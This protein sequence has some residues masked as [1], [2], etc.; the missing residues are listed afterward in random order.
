M[1]YGKNIHS[2]ANAELQQRRNQAFAQAEQ[3][4]EIFFSQYPRAKEI[5]YLLQSTSAAAGKAVLQ[6][7]NVREALEALK[8]E[9]LALQNELTQLYK[10]AGITEADLQEQFTCKLCGDTGNI[11]GKQCSCVRHLLKETAYNEL[12]ALSP[13]ALSTFNSFSLEYYP[14]QSSSGVNPQ[15]RMEQILQ[16]C[17]KYASE[18][19]SSSKSL[20]MRGTTGL[21]KTHLSLAIANEV[22]ENGFGVIYC[23][24]P[25]ILSKLEK[26][27]F[28][29]DK[30]ANENT[31]EYLTHCDLLILDDLG[32][33][34]ITQFTTSCIYNI[35]NTRIMLGLPT[36]I[37]TNM[38]FHELEKTYSQR[39]VSRIMGNSIKLDFI[40]ND[41]R[42]IKA[43]QK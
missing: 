2:K 9:N 8:N 3:K 7:Q 12:N 36:I 43:M 22:I 14:T 10:Q 4:K 33:E 6:G 18:F 20:L 42:Q 35:L 28:S 23:S 21:G 39:F 13:L 5:E 38:D 17:K 26:E 16:F 37:S 29:R 11:D 19:S 34:F 41:I 40:G 1:G 25:N 24:T 32:T 31:E 27:H 30:S 15:K